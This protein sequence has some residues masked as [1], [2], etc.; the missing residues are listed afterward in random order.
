MDSK[1][2]YIIKPPEFSGENV[3]IA[4]VARILRKD[5]QYIRQGIIKGYLPIGVA[6]KNDGSSQYD[7]YVSPMLLWKFTGHIWK[8]DTVNK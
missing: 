8:G 5:S 4:E 6:V 3:P 2:D 1:Y 7:F